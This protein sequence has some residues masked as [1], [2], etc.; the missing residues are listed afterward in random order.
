[1]SDSRLRMAVVGVGALGRHH[2][3][4][5]S[6]MPTVNLVAVV[7]GQRERG[8]EIARKCGTRYL[9]E[10]DEL[11]DQVDAVS[12]VVPTVAHRA[13]AGEFLRRHI[14]VLVEKPLADSVESA[15]ELVDLA[16]ETGTLL[17]VG[18]I[19]RFNPAM[20]AAMPLI[21]EPK[22]IRVER[23]SSYTFRSTDIGVVL[24]LMIHDIDLVAALA[25]SPTRQI[26]AFGIGVMGGHE[27]AVQARIVFENGCVADLCAS[28]ISPVVNR[29]LQIWSRSGC[30]NVDLHK[31]EVTQFS[32]SESLLFGASPLDRARQPGA[33]IERLKAEVFGGF[34]KVD[35]LP[36]QNTDALTEELAAFVHSVKTGTRPL[37]SGP[38]ALTAITIADQVLARVAA[39][40]WDGHAHGAIG[41]NIRKP[42]R[43]AS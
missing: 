31:R 37:V 15:A 3:R 42:L 36:V 6:E 13:V 2:A 34:V 35:A 29:T 43:K 33:D 10:V 11:Y 25:Q 18:H 27:D 23:T 9:A 41:P 8:E 28:R 1:M 12:V 24:D 30:V 32:P 39:H 26:D 40:Q 20:Q 4:I 14:P 17:Q 16:E 38:E 21:H 22:Y 7:D 5:L 19:E